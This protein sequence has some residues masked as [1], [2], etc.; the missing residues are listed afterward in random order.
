MTPSATHDTPS[1]SRSTGNSGGSVSCRKWL[2]VWPEPMS[3]MTRTSS[4]S[5]R[6]TESS[7]LGRR[8]QRGQVRQHLAREALDRRRGL[9]LRDVAEDRT[10]DE[11]R[12]RAHGGL[13]LELLA[14]AR[15]GTRHGKPAL[16][17]L[18][19]VAREADRRRAEVAPQLG[20]I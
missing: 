7:R 17:R 16:P 1:S 6:S 19:E 12:A 15:G 11:I 8:L 9:R 4:R 18:V 2:T 10:D 14:H 3:A 20:E 13:P 5:E